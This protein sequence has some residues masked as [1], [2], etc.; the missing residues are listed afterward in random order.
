M[1]EACAKDEKIGNGIIATRDY[2]YD[3]LKVNATPTFIINGV[4]HEGHGKH[5]HSQ[6][7]PDAEIA[8]AK[9][10]QEKYAR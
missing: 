7:R 6:D 9:G 8:F 3:R 5:Q 1:F 10:S 4:K 2:A